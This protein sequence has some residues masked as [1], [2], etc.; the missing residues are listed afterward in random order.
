L[1]S[2]TDLLGPWTNVATNSPYAAS[3]TN[4]MIFYRAVE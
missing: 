4:T 2:A 3:A 1:E